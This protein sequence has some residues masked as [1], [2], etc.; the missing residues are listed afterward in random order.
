MTNLY[1]KY[2]N[3]IITFM[4]IILLLLFAMGYCLNGFLGMKFE[5]NSIWS[6]LAIIITSATSTTA[7]YFISSKY[8]SKLGET[9]DEN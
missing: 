1:K 4:V 7:K 6:G 3:E 9:P 5:L 2:W 8:N